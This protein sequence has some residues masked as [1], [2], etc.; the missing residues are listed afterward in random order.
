MTGP[1]ISALVVA[2][3]FCGGILGLLLPLVLPRG[4]LTKETQD[5][6][7]LGTGMISVLASLVLG[8]LISTA[9]S[10]SDGTDHAMRTFSA[11]LIM[12]DETLRDYGDEAGTPRETLRRYTMRALQDHWPAGDTRAAKPDNDATGL[13][14]ERVREQIR[15]LKPVDD[16]QKDL[17]Q[18]AIGLNSALLRE[19]WLLIQEE[20][21]GV[22]PLVLAVLVAWV[23]LIFTSFG[24]NAPRNG[25]VVA[26]FFVCA[27]AIGGSVF[28]IMELD[29]PFAGLLRISSAPME[30]ALAHMSGTAK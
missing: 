9:K 28:L 13:L 8:L 3:V 27:V 4:H 24:L 23:F 14:L 17:R 2:L 12:L 6:V 22:R 7:R 5:V 25:T 26:A 15:G 1:W 11:D 19:R 10:S 21:P 18:E 20:G 29:S 16:G 30:N